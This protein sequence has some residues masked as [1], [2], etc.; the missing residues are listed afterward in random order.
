MR[1]CGS[2]AARS[3]AASS[4]SFGGRASRVRGLARR[5]VAAA[6]RAG[7]RRSCR[8]SGVVGLVVLV[9]RRPRVRPDVRRHPARQRLHLGDVPAPRALPARALAGAGDRRGGRAGGRRAGARAR[10]SPSGRRRLDVGRARRRAATVALRRRARRDELGEPRI[11]AATAA[12]T[13]SSTRSSTR[14]RRTRR[15][16]PS[17]M[18]RRRCGTPSYVLG[19]GPTSSIVDDT[20]IVY[21]GWGTRERRI[22]SLICERPVFILRLEDA[23][24]GPDPRGLPA[25]AVHHGHGRPG[26]TS[27]TVEPAGL[28][29]R[30]ARRRRLRRHGTGAGLTL[31]RA[32]RRYRATGAGLGMVPEIGPG[33]HRCG[34][35]VIRVSS[36]RCTFTSCTKSGMPSAG[37]RASRYGH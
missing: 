18:P 35:R 26:R 19:G 4:G 2:S 1:S 9:R 20:N 31:P 24:L 32:S 8:S 10:G 25:R 37:P 22:A 23:D 5:A 16:C 21:E 30:A 11:G 33:F 6:R 34:A 28:S 17:G 3:S 29:G 12:P 14:C 15:S 7:R 27:A 13:S 36:L